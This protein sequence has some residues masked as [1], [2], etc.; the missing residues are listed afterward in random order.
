MKRLLWTGCFIV[1]AVTVLDALL[2]GSDW[3]LVGIGILMGV[4][5]SV[6]IALLAAMPG[7]GR[8]QQADEASQPVL[9][10]EAGPD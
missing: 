10:I 8:A 2:V 4:A 1:I 3:S 9:L 6:P 5:L 7:K